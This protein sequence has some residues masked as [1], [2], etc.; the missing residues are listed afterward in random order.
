MTTVDRPPGGPANGASTLELEFQV[1]GMSCGSCA[2]RVER[3]L[4]GQPG[5][6]MATVNFATHRANVQLAEDEPAPV[7]Q[8]VAAV[9]KLGYGLTPRREAE[10]V[11]AP[12]ARATGPKD[13]G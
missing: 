7:D 10:A 9:Q 1:E 6:V 2:A 3:I 12:V 11:A 4:G 5:V 13:V 8:L